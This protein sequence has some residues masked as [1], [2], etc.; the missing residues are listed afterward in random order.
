MVLTGAVTICELGIWKLDMSLSLLNP[1]SR[2]RHFMGIS[3]TTSVFQSPLVRAIFISTHR[4]LHLIFDHHMSS[5]S[6]KIKSEVAFHHSPPNLKQK[7]LT[8]KTPKTPS[9]ASTKKTDR[10]L[11]KNNKSHDSAFPV[12]LSRFS[13]HP[14]SPSHPAMQSEPEKGCQRNS[15]RQAHSDVGYHSIAQKKTL[16]SHAF[17][18]IRLLGHSRKRS[19]SFLPIHSL[20]RSAFV[21]SS[22]FLSFL[23]GMFFASVYSRKL[24]HGF[25]LLFSRN[26]MVR[27]A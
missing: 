14:S 3:Y 2:I 7:T 1:S 18:S 10:K 15:H 5:A 9:R 19:F 12:R 24:R 27:T 4:L 6:S 20:L 8:K 22:A 11:I 26:I 16:F 21:R 25:T 17:I 23:H 13:L